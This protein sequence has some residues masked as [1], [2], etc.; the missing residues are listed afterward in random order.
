M[1]TNGGLLELKKQLVGTERVPAADYTELQKFGIPDLDR[2]LERIYEVDQRRSFIVYKY[3][4]DMKKNIEEDYRVL[5]PGRHF[6]ILVGDNV[7]RKVP[8]YT[9]KY[10]IDIAENMG[11]E[12]IEVGYDRIK[13]RGLAP[14]RHH[15]AGLIEVE[16]LMIFKKM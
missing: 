15:T 11:F 14:K 9:H 8:V 10:I 4:I 12:T 6:C 5:R 7:I 16:W 3:F 2:A 1:A 13:S